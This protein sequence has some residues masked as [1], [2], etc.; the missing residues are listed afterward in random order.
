MDRHAAEKL[1]KVAVGNEKASFRPG[2][3]ETIEALVNHRK[4]ILVVQKTGWGKSVIYFLSTR[5]LRQ[6]G[7]GPS[8]IV[9]PLLAL[10]RN[11]IEAAK[12][13]GIRAQT[14]NSSNRNRWSH[15]MDQVAA[16]QVDALLIS[17]ERLADENFVRKTLLPIADRVGLLVVDE[18]HCI[19]DWGHDFRPDYRRLLHILRYLPPNMPLLCTTATAN[20][21]VVRDVSSLLGNISIQRGPLI[22]ESLVL[23]AL[24]LPSQAARLA[25]LAQ[26]IP[27][28][29]GTGI[30]YVLTR[31]DAEKVADWLNRKGI[32]A[33]PYFSG[34]LEPDHENSD[35][36]RQHLEDLL[37][38][39]QLKVLV[40][41]T[42]LGMGYDKPDLGFVIHYQAPSS[43]LSYYQQV[44]RAGRALHTA[45]GI[46]LA[47]EEDEQVHEY[48]RRT[49][50]PEE[51]DVRAVLEV[52]EQSDGLT[53][54]QIGARLNIPPGVIEKI[55]KILSVEEPAPIFKDGWYWRRS[56]VPY[57]IDRMRIER[58]TR[59]RESEWRQVQG[60]LHS[61]TCLMVFLCRVLD[62]PTVRRCGRCSVC[63]GEHVFAPEADGDLLREA[64]LFL[65]HSERVFIPNR[66]APKG[67]FTAYGLRGRIPDELSAE[68][69]RILCRWGDTPWGEWVAQDKHAGRFREELVEAMAEMIVERWKP[70]PKPRWVTCVPS[71]RHPCLV[72]DMALRL[73]RRLGLPF[74]PSIQ[75]VRE[76]EP[77]KMQQNR[78]HQCKNLDGAFK[79]AGTVLPHPVLL[80]DDIVDS[81]W[82]MTL[83][84]VLLRKAGSGAVYPVALA[85][86]NPGG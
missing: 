1:L 23:D 79:V 25:W 6:K 75:K 16:D 53:R 61:S 36:S 49:A 4:R 57:R 67:V 63:R 29:P 28:L 39:N 3:W 85:S 7:A 27:K 12:R 15:I 32:H 78:Y 30:V 13:I 73:A 82:T 35:E 33:R 56:P 71:L 86:T 8:L 60:Y 80:V 19:S 83:A 20:D 17:P 81:G 76:N 46:M 44:G 34:V 58:L 65:R 59:Q 70:F 69:G 74:I 64:E 45:Y 84:A 47:G 14:I 54:A 37:L 68:R 50:F 2:Q 24:Y 62:D 52:L 18:A 72:P 66:Y 26:N 48:L 55:L 41:T 40:A 9:S 38:T 31:R 5:I 11:Q 22:R 21:R 10:M 43:I 51:E 42:A 77:Q